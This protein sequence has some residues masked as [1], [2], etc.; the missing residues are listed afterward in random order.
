MGLPMKETFS[1]IKEISQI[2]TT[3]WKSW[4]LGIFLNRRR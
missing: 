4:D 3:K 2:L 1:M